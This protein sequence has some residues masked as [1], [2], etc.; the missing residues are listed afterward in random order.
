ML[1]NL[2]NNFENILNEFNVKKKAEK[3]TKLKQII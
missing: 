1:P 3:N 2:L